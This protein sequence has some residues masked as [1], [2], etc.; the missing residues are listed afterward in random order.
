MLKPNPFEILFE[1]V[2]V[3]PVTAPNR[4]YQVP[5]AC[6]MGHLR[7]RAHAAMREVKAAGGWGVVCTEETEI[8]PSSDLSPYS[9]QRLW[10]ERDIPALSLMVDAVKAHGAL[11]GIELVHNG[12][13]A[14]NLYSRLPAMAPSDLQLDSGYPKM[15]RRMDAADI[16]NLRKWHRRAARN[17]KAAGFDIIYVYAGHEMT[18][19]QHFLLSRY[20][21]RADEYGG[22]L[23]NR[24]RLIRELLTETKE[25]VGDRCAVALRLAVDEGRGADGMQAHGEGRDVV[26][27][28]ADIPDLWDV[29]VSDWRNDTVSTRFE[30]D[31]GYQVERIRFV[32][33][34]TGKPTVGVGRF[35]SPDLMARLVRDGVLDFIGAARPS[36]ADPYLPKKIAEGRIEA[37]RE[38]IGCNIC[39]S[40]DKL[41]VPIRCTQN[42]TMGEEWRRGWNPEAIPRNASEAE[43]LVVG[44]GPAGLECAL[45]LGRRGYN[46]MLAEALGELGGRALRES[47]LLGLSA[48]RRVAENRVH[49]LRQMAN[50][51][52]Y[53]ESRLGAEDIVETGCAKAFLATGARWRNDGTGRTHSHPLQDLRQM[54]VFTPDDIMDGKLPRGPVVVYDD[55]HGYMGGVIADHLAAAGVDV[56]LVSTSAIVSPFTEN[57]LEQHRVQAALMAAGVRLVLSTRLDAV[58]DGHVI[59]A[60][61]YGG[62]AGT[63]NCAGL[64][65]V[66]ARQI[67]RSLE[68]DLAKRAPRLPVEVIGDALAPGLIADATFGGHLA[69]RSF[70]ADPDRVEAALFRREMPE[71]LPL[72]NL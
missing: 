21:Q 66:T 60:N 18:I 42:P 2:K 49:E 51:D 53:V 63:I 13:M 57:T 62:D 8:H 9:E 25:E 41:G 44:A 12:H 69:A 1:S 43:V 30:L 40:S 10:D 71:L 6:G 38:C 50:V 70:E 45:Q 39:A 56:T 35:T 65:L 27:L 5:H 36:I 64:V 22:S 37:I 20:N 59:V 33:E 68:V 19:P 14:P 48:W 24:A 55:D 34:A 28:L 67:D 7:P 11:A 31:E 46:V 16:R 72:S 52:L 47:R 17:A 15:A 3:G 32:R 54:P 58:G 4:F 23:E 61:V 26:E 29:N